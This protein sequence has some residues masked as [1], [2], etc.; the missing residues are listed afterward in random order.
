MSSVDGNY[1]PDIDGLRAIAVA[2]VVFYHAFDWV[3]PGGFVGVDI[4]FVISGYLIS[5]VLVK[6]AKPGWSTVKSFYVRRIR[7]IFPALILVLLF[8]ILFGHYA[9]LE[10]EYAQLGKHVMGAVGFVSNIVLWR[11]A[12]YFDVGSDLKPLLHLWSLGVEEQFYI[13]WPLFLIVCVRRNITVVLAAMLFTLLSFSWSVATVA[14][15]PTAGFYLPFARAWE[16]TLGASLAFALIELQK[17]RRPRLAM[18][19]AWVGRYGGWLGVALIVASLAG[20][21]E[22]S[23][24]PGWNALPPVAG[25]A[26]IVWAGMRSWVN[27]R[28]LATAP[29]VFIGLISYPLYLWHWPL[30]SFMRIVGASSQLN[31]AVAMVIAVVLAWL[32]YRFVEQPVRTGALTVPRQF[33][34]FALCGALLACGALGFALV[35]GML[36]ARSAAD[37]RMNSIVAAAADWGFQA[38]RTLPGATAAQALFFGDSHMQQYFP[39]LEYLAT[40]HLTSKTV[41]F[42]TQGGCTPFPDVERRSQPCLRFVEDGFNSAQQADTIVIAASWRGFLERHDYYW[43]HDPTHR[44]FAASSGADVDAVIQAFGARLAQLHLAGKRVVVVL[45]SP[46]GPGVDPRSMVR[47]NRLQFDWRPQTVSL[48]QQL[49]LVGSIDAKIAAAA[50]AAGA[51]VV[52]PLHFFCSALRCINTLDGDRPVFVDSSHIRSSFVRTRVTYLDEFVR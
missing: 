47:R 46:R 27:R 9:L 18:V 20:L 25:S 17:G 12:G 29:L 1:R 23:T 30:L 52:T 33:V 22:H 49:L 16:L 41:V 6:D 2:A 45:S 28:L 38:D 4:F 37:P 32:T 7:R 21:D 3:L 10:D 8:C 51:E 26:L 39:R 42:K 48:D 31:N 40:Q 44:S 24:F 35:S 19:D 34:S 5:S 13:F 36:P 43:A 15:F 14:H 50:K 11:E